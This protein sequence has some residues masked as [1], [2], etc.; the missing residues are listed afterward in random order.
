MATQDEYRRKA[1]LYS[2]LAEVC[3]DRGLADR[4][5]TAA[6]DYFHLCGEARRVRQQSR[7]TTP[8]SKETRRLWGNGGFRLRARFQRGTPGGFSVSD[9]VPVPSPR[10]IFE[11]IA[12]GFTLQ[13]GWNC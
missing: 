8:P 10:A 12:R 2:R 7:P 5:R 13:L 9:L 1:E 6:A 3:T 11:V 4:L